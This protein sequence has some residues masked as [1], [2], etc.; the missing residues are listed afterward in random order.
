MKS[1][2]LILAMFMSSSTAFAGI[3]CTNL[4]EGIE[5]FSIEYS[6]I[7]GCSMTLKKTDDTD[8]ITKVI[9]K[10][11][12]GERFACSEVIV[13][14]QVITEATLMIDPALLE[15]GESYPDATV[16]V[17]G[18]IDDLKMTFTYPKN[19]TWILKGFTCVQTPDI[20]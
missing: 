17:E 1:L 19:Y 8:F 20:E 3:Q 7:R 4:K 16:K 15:P 5:E 11:T 14:N 13:G 9:D 2:F 12:A 6:H 18:G 10:G